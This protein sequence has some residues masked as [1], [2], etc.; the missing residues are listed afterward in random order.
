MNDKDDLSISSSFQLPYALPNELWLYLYELA[1]QREDRIHLSTTCKYFRSL[2][3]QYL[4]KQIKHYT[5]KKNL[6]LSTVLPTL[7]FLA[8]HFQSSLQYLDLSFADLCDDD[9]R[10]SL[11]RFQQLTTLSLTHCPNITE[12]CIEYIP[13]SVVH[14]D[15][16]FSPI[17]PC[18]LSNLPPNLISLTL[19]YCKERSDHER[20]SSGSSMPTG[21]IYLNESHLPASL[22]LLRAPMRWMKPDSQRFHRSPCD[23]QHGMYI[24]NILLEA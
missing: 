17:C 9:L 15:L 19:I 8:T 5:L 2:Y 18:N 14:L 24:S 3:Y 23:D 22:Q 13:R 16:S 7:D 1:L 12:K 11:P 20:K 6:P 4:S 21:R 10:R